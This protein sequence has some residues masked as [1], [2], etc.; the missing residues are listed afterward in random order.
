MHCVRCFAQLSCT[1]SAKRTRTRKME[2]QDIFESASNFDTHN[3]RLAFF[4]V[5]ASFILSFFHHTHPISSHSNIITALSVHPLPP[6]P[7]SA[8]S[9]S[10]SSSSRNASISHSHS[11]PQSS[12]HAPSHK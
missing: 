7:S 11:H 4:L 5:F 3:I 8:P 10:S 9:S 6:S 12:T 1:A 2:E